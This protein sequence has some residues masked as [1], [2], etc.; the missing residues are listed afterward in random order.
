MV[1]FHNII[2]QIAYDSPDTC[3]GIQIAFSKGWQVKALMSKV[4]SELQFYNTDNIRMKIKEKSSKNVDSS[5][6]Q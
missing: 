1:S 2:I 5:K 3:W 6:Q 4:I